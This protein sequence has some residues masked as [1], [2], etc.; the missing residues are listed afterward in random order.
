MTT[1]EDPL[2]LENIPDWVKSGAGI[3][4][5]LIICIVTAIILMFVFFL[6]VKVGLWL[7][8]L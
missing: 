7:V 1:D 4:A 2:N 6:V 3:V 8:G 5:F